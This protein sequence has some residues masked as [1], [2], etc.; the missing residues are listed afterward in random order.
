MIWRA[1]GNPFPDANA[2][3]KPG[4]VKPYVIRQGDYLKRI[5]HTLG[6]D[7][8]AAWSH[9][10][11]AE[12]ADKR[13]PNL[14][15]PGDIL[16]VPDP[17][18]KWETL[19]QGTTNTYAVTVP[20]TRVNLAFKDANGPIANAAY[21]AEGLGDKQHGT[22]D[23]NGML[24]LKVPVHVTECQVT[25]PDKNATYPVRVGH[26][27]PI[28]EPSGVRKRLEHMGYVL[29]SEGDPLPLTDDD[30]GARDRAGII[31]FQQEHGLNPTGVVDDATKKAILEKHAD[32][33]PHRAR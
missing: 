13:E 8:D 6:F 25:F 31:D 14:L 33:N 32:P 3:D 9:P 4:T 21:V 10:K 15:H 27:D 19:N 1:G 12:M 28:D 5:A 24:S 20:T 30:I 18:P 26:M 29:R 16:Y 2:Q 7:A 17:N 23:G 11:N 22:T